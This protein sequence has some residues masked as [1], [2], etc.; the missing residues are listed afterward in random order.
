MKIRQKEV[1]LSSGLGKKQK[2]L[3]TQQNWAAQ[4]VKLLG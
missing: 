3:L 4:A 2:D 1:D